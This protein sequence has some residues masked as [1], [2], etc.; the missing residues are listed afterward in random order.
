MPHESL[1][2]K[3]RSA[4]GEDAAEACAV[5][6]RSITE[7]CQLDHLGNEER[8]SK[9][10]SNKTVENVRRWILESQFLVA[11]HGERIVGVATMTDSGRITL[12]YVDPGVRFRGVSKALMFSMEE[13]ARTLG[14]T[15]CF[16]ETTQTALRFYIASG[17]VKSEQTHVLPLTGSPATVLSKHLQLQKNQT[18]TLPST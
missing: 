2:I 9:W 13:N 17:Y 18:E 7:L 11:E 5:I 16:L 15:S 1:S 6:R 12:N 10:L 8:L 14:I 3:I 4:K